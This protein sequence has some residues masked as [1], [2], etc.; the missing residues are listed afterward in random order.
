MLEGGNQICT[1]RDFN[2]QQQSTIFARYI[3]GEIK[4]IILNTCK[5]L[6]IK[7]ET[8]LEL[9]MYHQQ[10]LHSFVNSDVWYMELHSKM[11]LL[12]GKG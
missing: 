5:K 2:I 8:I 9:R 12:R 4:V 3:I 11:E 7:L 1:N 10:P 6:M